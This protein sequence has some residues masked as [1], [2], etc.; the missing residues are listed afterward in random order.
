MLRITVESMLCYLYK[1]AQLGLADK[2]R[3]IKAFDVCNCLGSRAFR[4]VKRSGSR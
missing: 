3:A 2:G 4:P 1:G